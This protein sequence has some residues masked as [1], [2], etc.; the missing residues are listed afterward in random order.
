MRATRVIVASIMIILSL[1]AF[2]DEA[3]LENHQWHIA[4]RVLIFDEESAGS[5]S[6]IAQQT[7]MSTQGM[8]VPVRVGMRTIYPVACSDG[9]GKPIACGDEWSDTKQLWM[10]LRSVMRDG[11]V[12]TDFELRGGA[13]KGPRDIEPT[14]LLSQGR[15]QT[16]PGAIAKESVALPVPGATEPVRYRVEVSVYLMH[17]L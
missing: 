11:L 10:N 5:G 8:V 1:A 15:W 12:E 7:V 2:A 6:L 17:L 14:L 16:A 4:Y 3:P 9:P 13:A